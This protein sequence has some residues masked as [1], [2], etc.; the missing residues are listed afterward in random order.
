MKEQYDE[1]NKGYDA[2]DTNAPVTK[3]EAVATEATTEAT[4]QEDD[5]E[6]DEYEFDG[7]GTHLPSR[8]LTEH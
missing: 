6:D 5:E 4:K 8:Y 7:H 1:N 3:V 2:D